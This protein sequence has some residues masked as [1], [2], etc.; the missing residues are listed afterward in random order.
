MEAMVHILSNKP[1]NSANKVDDDFAVMM[2][3][4]P[5]APWSLV[6]DDPTLH[7]ILAQLWRQIKTQLWAKGHP[8]ASALLQAVA[9]MSQCASFRWDGAQ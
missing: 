2:G 4:Y 6:E 8:K 5:F 3:E 1:R 7:P 9:M